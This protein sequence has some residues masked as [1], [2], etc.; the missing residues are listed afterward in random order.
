MIVD[1]GQDVCEVGLRIEAVHL[2]RFNDGHRACQRFG[3][4]VC[5]GKEPVLPSDANRAQGALGWI[6]VDSDPTVRQE[7]AEGVLAAEPVTEGLGQ[8]AL[9]GDQGELALGPCEEGRDLRGAVRLTCGK[10]DVGGTAG[11]LAFDVIERADT[12]ERLAGDGGF[13][14]VPFVVEVATQVGPAGCLPQAGRPIGVRIVKLGITLVTIGLED[15]AGLGQ[16]AMDVFFLPI[17][18]EGIDSAGWRGACPRA[19]VAI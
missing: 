5:P 7:Q 17:W 8:I 2:G 14:L 10:A 1:A 9:A 18:R 19:L 3:T 11:D 13:R 6:V 15:A 12:V 4:C 16:M